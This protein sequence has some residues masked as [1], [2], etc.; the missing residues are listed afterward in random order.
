MLRAG[1]GVERV[2]RLLVV[3]H[4]DEVPVLEEARVL[5]A[6]EV[7]GAAELEPAV[8]V[9][10]GAGA[11]RPG[12]AGLPE[13]LAA[14][15][16]ARSARAARRPPCQASIASSSGPRPSASSPSK[17][18]IQMRSAGKPKPSRESSQANSTAPC[19]K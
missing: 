6:R 13:V 5:A 1:S 4:E 19:L 18:V 15:A 7:V 9:E 8:E 10:L 3:L 12:R 17:T 11:A 14:R 2:G 16:Q